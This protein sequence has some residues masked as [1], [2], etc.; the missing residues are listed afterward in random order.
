MIRR[1][2]FQNI[3]DNATLPRESASAFKTGYYD[4]VL[5]QMVKIIERTENTIADNDF[6][7][8]I[9]PAIRKAVLVWRQIEPN[10]T[11]SISK[12]TIDIIK[13]K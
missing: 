12:A 2:I 10:M 9:K 1:V 13:N 7:C 5:K 4:I 8:N 6:I 3:L 11:E